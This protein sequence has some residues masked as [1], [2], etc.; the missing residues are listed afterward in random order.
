MMLPHQVE[1]S[2][3]LFRDAE[4]SISAV[5]FVVDSASR[6]YIYQFNEGLAL[7]K[8][9]VVRFTRRSYCMAAKNTHVYNLIAHVLKCLKLRNVPF[10]L[11]L[12]P[13]YGN[14]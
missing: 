1:P 12:N 4:I 8:S 14:I 3:C 10:H 7:E 13:V 2:L 11:I 6:N 5:L 9:A